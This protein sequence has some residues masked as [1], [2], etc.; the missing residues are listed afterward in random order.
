MI[1]DCSGEPSESFPAAIS[2]RLEDGRVGDGTS[3]ALKMQEGAKG[4]EC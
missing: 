4:N 2:G 3:L 1:L